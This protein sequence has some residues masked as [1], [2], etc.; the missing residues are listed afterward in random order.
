MI[1]RSY[2]IQIHI[3]IYMH[4][5]IPYHIIPFHYI[6]YHIYIIICIY[7]YY[8]IY[9][10]SSRA[11]LG[12]GCF[13]G[14]SNCSFQPS[15]WPSEFPP[16]FPWRLPP[17]WPS[18]ARY[19]TVITE[20]RSRHRETLSQSIG[21][22]IFTCETHLHWMKMRSLNTKGKS[23]RF[24]GSLFSFLFQPTRLERDDQSLERLETTL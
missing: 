19:C 7:I 18:L 8:T 5:Y 11:V 2:T 9:C 10:N 3:Y 17:R 24:R 14:P 15:L 1:P 22:D 21:L 13:F 16:G 23:S 6:T 4:I 20:V 12:A